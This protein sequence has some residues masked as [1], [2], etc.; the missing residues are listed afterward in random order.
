MLLKS[1][2]T[3]TGRET[4]VPLY[5]SRRF[6]WP[7]DRLVA[8]AAIAERLQ[9]IRDDDVFCGSVAE[10]FVDGIHVAAKEG[11]GFFIAQMRISSC[12][13]TVLELGSSRHTR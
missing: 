6:T 10:P 13:Y 1:T 4:F 12:E 7:S 5:L 11:R 9:S 8:L 3:H 2:S